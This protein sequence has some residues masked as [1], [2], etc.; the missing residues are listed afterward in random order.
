MDLETLSH[1]EDILNEFVYDKLDSYEL[2]QLWRRIAMIPGMPDRT[3]IPG[4][5][6][7]AI[8]CVKHGGEDGYE[9]VEETTYDNMRVYRWKK[10][11]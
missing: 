4:P 2:K 9:A 11:D 10:I 3:D 7:A 5:I 8:S 1:L 6:G